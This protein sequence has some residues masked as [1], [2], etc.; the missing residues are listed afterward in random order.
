MT[1][2][3][4]GLAIVIATITIVGLIEARIKSIVKHYLIELKPNHGSSVK[5]QVSRL[6]SRVDEIYTLLINKE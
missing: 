6:E 4:V 2:L 5:D 3:E 1:S